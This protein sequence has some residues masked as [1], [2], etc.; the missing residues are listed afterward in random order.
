MLLIQRSSCL[1]PLQMIA[2]FGAIMTLVSCGPQQ[3][4][5]S[6]PNLAGGGY[7]Y[8]NMVY[9]RPNSDVGWRC[10]DSLGLR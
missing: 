2:C 1:Q 7:E 3:Q 10:T 5:P 8:P 6:K 9:K 4:Q